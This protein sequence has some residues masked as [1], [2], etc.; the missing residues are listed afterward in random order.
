MSR[1]TDEAIGLFDSAETYF[2]NSGMKLLNQNLSAA[3]RQNADNDALRGFWSMAAGLSKL[4]TG[5]RATYILLEE[6]KASLEKRK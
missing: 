6:V 3:E 1:P 5:M 2:K 4:S